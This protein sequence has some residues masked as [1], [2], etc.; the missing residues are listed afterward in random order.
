MV[1]DVQG[2]KLARGQYWCTD[3]I[4]HTTDGGVG[5]IDHGQEGINKWLNLY[6]EE[7]KNGLECF[8]SQ[9]HFRPSES[10]KNK[11]KSLMSELIKLANKSNFKNISDMVQIKVRNRST[12]R[13]RSRSFG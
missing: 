5:V 4:V 6:E 10:D 2:V 9:P 8:A 1:V 7:L 11:M 13:S 3:P 12:S